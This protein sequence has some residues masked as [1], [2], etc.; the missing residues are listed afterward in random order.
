VID[1]TYKTELSLPLYYATG[2]DKPMGEGYI[3]RYPKSVEQKRGEFRQ[4]VDERRW[5]TLR[6]KWG[7][8]YLVAREPLGLKE[9]FVDGQV[10]VYSLE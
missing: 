7:F 6:K 1:T 9:L 3:S 8:K 5:A 10:R 2:Y 4:L